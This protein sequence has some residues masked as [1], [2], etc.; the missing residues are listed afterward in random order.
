MNIFSRGKNFTL[1]ELLVVISIIAILAA[2]LIP[3]LNKA[4]E[5]SRAVA[6]V[7]GLKQV[8]LGQLGYL[9]DSD[10][11][12]PALDYGGAGNRPWP[13]AIYPYIANREPVYIYGVYQFLDKTTPYQCPSQKVWL[14]SAGYISYGYNHNALGTSS[15]AGTSYYGCP[16][17]YPVKLGK[18]R[19]PG[20][21][22]VFAESWYNSTSLDGRSSGSYKLDGQTYL[23]FRHD[24]RCNSAYADGHV[25]PEKQDWLWLSD[26]RYYPFNAG[27]TN[28]DYAT[29]AAVEWEAQ[30]GYYPY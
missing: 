24:R 3:A 27:Q 26:S 23:C 2:M 17:S 1:I 8:L 22:L 11:I 19:K 21:Q 30:Y 5:R 16:V 20:S 14:Q 29:R 9:N 28:R 6:C 12:F 25:T 7:S 13:A 18:I 4:R 15:Y 10:D